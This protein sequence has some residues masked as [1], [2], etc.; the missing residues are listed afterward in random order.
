MLLL[1]SN[2]IPIISFYHHFI[3]VN[4]TLSSSKQFINDLPLFL[5]V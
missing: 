1:V 5:M 4:G 2:H 3:P